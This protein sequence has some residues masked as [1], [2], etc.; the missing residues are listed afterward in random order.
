M[1]RI[2][3]E[4]C[5]VLHTRPYRESS[6]IVS[7]LSLRH[8]RLDAVAKGVRGGRRGRIL[9]PFVSLSAGW[10]G[11]TSLGTLTNFEAQTQRWFKGQ[12][13]ASA[14][15]LTEL[16]MR[17]V[18]EREAHPRLF[19]GLQWSLD[20]IEADLEF[21][22]RSFEKLLL[23]KLGYG[24]DFEL[25]TEGSSIDDQ[26]VYQLIPDQGFQMSSEGFP[27]A[28]LKRVGQEDF[29]APE[30]RRVAKKVLREALSHQLGPKPLA[31]R[32]LLTG[33]S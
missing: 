29:A 16:I 11:R 18:G 5:I 1:T 10:T 33:R 23:E 19:V 13:L 12:A 27:G 15:Y 14:F 7:L 22:L 2:E 20:N 31:S 24:I 28:L 3:D 25:D 26:T 17:L 21:T 9:Q 30:V 32:R 6:L 8:G 4:P